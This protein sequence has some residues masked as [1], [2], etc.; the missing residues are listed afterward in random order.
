MLRMLHCKACV[1]LF[2]LVAMGAGAAQGHQ[3]LYDQD[4][5]RLAVG[6]EAGL[7]GFLVGNVDT[8]A[9]NINTDAPLEGPFPPS[10]RRTTRDWFEGFGKPFAELETPLFGFGHSYALVSMVGALT[11]GNGDALSSLAP[12]AARSTTS[13]APQH[14]ALE[15]AFLGWHSGDLF[16][17]T[18]G[19]DAIELSGGRQSFVLGDAFLIGTGVANGFGRAALYLQPRASFDHVALLKLNLSPV[20]ARLFNLENRVNQD[21]MQGFDQPKS[22]FFG[23]DIGLFAASEAEQSAKTMGQKQAPKA[24]QAVQTTRV[25]KEVPDLWSA[26]FEFFH[27]YDADSA[28]ETFSF[29]PGEPAPA[30]SIFGNRNGLNV[31]SGYL[32]GSLFE[33]DR[34]ILLYSQF[35]L[36]RNDAIDRRV[37]AAAWYVEPGY[38]FSLPW[39]PQL[40]LRYAH[41]SGDPNPND[42][43]KQSYDPLFNTGGS[44]G[45]GSWF[46]GEIFGQYISAN[47]NLDLEMVHLKFSPLDT[48]DTGIL[49]YNFRFDQTAQLNNPLITSKNAAQEVDFYS[50]WS[51]AEWL[52]VTGVI[53]FA[54]PGAGL[55]QAAQAFVIDNGPVGRSVGRTMT[56]AEA[57]VAIKY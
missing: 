53:A 33:F 20:R 11:R 38:K 9:G 37:Q 2:V 42:R 36:E 5:Y 34:N 14:A 21:L 29:P 16:A 12:Q 13:D 22:Q 30:L 54:V 49:Y 10:V 17:D 25:K 39:S 51:A 23:L 52:T 8:A 56:L 47:T 31:Y 27:F 40:N 48:L 4:G 18:L 50:V 35:A 41:F 1:T 57:F 46:L 15:D 55:K 45:F 43:L 32:A 3:M 28:L 6:I 24:A 19:E 44:R 26:G 7:G